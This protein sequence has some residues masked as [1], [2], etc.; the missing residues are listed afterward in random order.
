ML[1]ELWRTKLCTPKEEVDK[2]KAQQATLEE[3]VNQL[4]ED[5]K[6]A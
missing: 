5:S 6:L 4:K 3:H 2:I 1:K